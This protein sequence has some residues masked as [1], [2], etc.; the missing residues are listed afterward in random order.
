MQ[1]AQSVKIQTNEQRTDV[2]E[3]AVLR[4]LVKVSLGIWFAH[5]I[6]GKMF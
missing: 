3:P 2:V 5:G 4:Q 1:N 6:I